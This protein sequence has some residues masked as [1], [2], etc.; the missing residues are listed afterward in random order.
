M[1]RAD[2]R[3]S[4]KAKNYK[5]FNFVVFLFLSENALSL[6]LGE[7]P[8]EEREIQGELLKF[9]ADKVTATSSKVTEDQQT[10]EKVSKGKFW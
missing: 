6:E 7:T 3:V 10:Y 2:G 5:M 8:A 4:F 9:K 1:W